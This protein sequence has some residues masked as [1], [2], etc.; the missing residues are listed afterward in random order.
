MRSPTALF[1]S[2]LGA[3]TTAAIACAVSPV[4]QA[5]PTPRT[6][7]APPAQAHSIVPPPVT[8]EPGSA[9]VGSVAPVGPVKVGLFLYSIQ[10]LDFSRHTFRPS[11]EVWF[12][13]RGD[14]FDP[15][16]N[17]HVVGAR[18]TTITV[19]DRR[20]LPNDENY[21]V[22]RVDAV[23]NGTF[24]T[25]AF[26]FDQHRLAIAIES[27]FEDDY[28][29]FEVDQEA[30]MLDPDAFSPGWRLA[31]FTVREFRKHYPT[32]FG[33]AER[34]GDRYSTLVAEVVAQRIG[35]RAAIDYFIGF[36]VCVLLCLLG[37][38]I[39]VHLLA[40]RTTVLTAATIAAVGNKY[41]VNSLTETNVTAP[42]V[43]VAIIS[44]FA[45]VL[46]F[47]L[48]SVRCERIAEAGD[49]KRAE[50]INRDVGF[51][52]AVAYV[53]VMLLVLWRAL[54]AGPT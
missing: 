27:P 35:W 16:A 23:I 41:V 49:R 15:I 17:L 42:L 36:I 30:S 39:P 19:E 33:L 6:A 38:F 46:I 24:D 26:P 45:M 47:M 51:G 37:Y 34:V 21:V 44:A 53:L 18:S 8:R 13:W 48:T 54:A 31:G 14:A 9:S 52:S 43:N 7:I 11:F 1:R 5:Q 3:L 10:E 50:R 40:A 29:V 22:A 12:R 2:L 20:R 32:S 4:A 25:G 28:V